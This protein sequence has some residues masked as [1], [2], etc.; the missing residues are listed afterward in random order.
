MPGDLIAGHPLA[1]D[2]LALISIEC[3]H[4]HNID[5]LHYVINDSATSFLSRTIAQAR[6]QA[7]SVGLEYMVVA[8]ENRRPTI[9]LTSPMVG[10][11]ASIASASTR[12]GQV[13]LYH[14]LHGGT[15]VMMR[16]DQ[17]IKQVRPSKFVD[18]LTRS[19][20]AA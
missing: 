10:N 11:A 8:K 12:K 1:F 4:R 15:V 17:F 2:F 6:D 19:R 5:L 13:L 18:V 14:T 7:R 16:L 3:K 9:I 20:R